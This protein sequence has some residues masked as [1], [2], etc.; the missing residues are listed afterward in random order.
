MFSRL[1]G[2]T[3]RFAMEITSHDDWKQRKTRHEAFLSLGSNLGDKAGNLEQARLKLEE[4]G[5]R[6]EKVSPVYLTEPVDFKEQNWFLNQ[7]LWVSTSLDP[8]QLLQLCLKIEGDMGRERR[9]AKG[10]RNIDIDVLLYQDLVMESQ[11]LTI[12]HPRLHLRR[13]VLQALADLAPDLVHPVLLKPIIELLRGCSDPAQMRQL[14]Q[15]L[16]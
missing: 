6:L 9:V 16:E 2:T 14:G 8:A 10:P 1:E 13:F 5:V 4:S 12:P 7:V 3:G 11:P 15:S